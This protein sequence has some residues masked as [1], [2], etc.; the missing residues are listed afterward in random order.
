MSP[1]RFVTIKAAPIPKGRCP[2]PRSPAEISVIPRFSRIS[3]IHSEG[4]THPRH[5]RYIFLELGAIPG[6]PGIHREIP[7]KSK[8]SGSLISPPPFEW[9]KNGLP[10]APLDGLSY[11]STKR[12]LSF[13]GIIYYQRNYNIF[14]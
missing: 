10:I 8:T 12:R 11:H 4:K 14:K 5:P 2:T 9:K 1:Y 3:K 13:R 7:N 6:Y